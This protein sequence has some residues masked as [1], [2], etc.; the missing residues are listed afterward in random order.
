MTLA[1]RQR[2]FSIEGFARVTT[3]E[4]K[5]HD[6]MV[7]E[8]GAHQSKSSVA[9]PDS[10]PLSGKRVLVTRARLQASELVAALRAAGAEPVQFPTIEIAPPSDHFAGLDR[11]I[12]D[13]T[14]PPGYDWIVFTSVNGVEMF[15]SRLRA[16]GLDARSLES[17]RFAVI[18]AA[19]AE[20]LERHGLT[21]DVVPDRFVA[22]ALLHA[23]PNPAGCRFLLPRANIA[24]AALREGLEA[25]GADVHEVEAYQTVPGEPS[26]AERAELVE[27]GVDV[28]TFT[29]SSTV[30]YFFRQLGLQT[31]RQV[32]AGA[33]VA[34]IGPITTG[35]AR[36][37]GLRVDLEAPEHTIPGLVA[38]L[39]NHYRE[40][41]QKG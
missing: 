33:L 38:A 17:V 22:E 27:R 28:I 2:D 4:G 30:R 23:I 25:L 37:L 40:P 8:R 19:T 26:E 6:M 16:V 31:A 12:A 29:S 13:L 14:R 11:A 24:R 32:T 15:F 20:A 3:G 41:A 39:V 21:A 35:T 9:A 36:E 34:T 18:G 10:R 7:P 5:R 1:N